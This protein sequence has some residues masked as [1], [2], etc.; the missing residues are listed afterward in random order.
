[1]PLKTSCRRVTIVYAVC[2]A[3]ATKTLKLPFLRLNRAKAEEFVRLQTLNTAV[4]ND[5]L[6]MPKAQRRALTSMSFAH[7]AIGAAWINQ[8]IRNANAHTKV[9]Q[10]RCLPLETNN[11][12]WTLH[13]VGETFSVA[14]GLLRGIKK[15]VP[16]AV[17]QAAHRQ[18]LNA[19]LDGSAKAG[20]LKLWRSQKGI[21]H[22]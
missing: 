19:V 11:Q 1:M 2:M 17:H 15:R 16:L 12:N 9:K 5:I 22:T 13:K 4:A 8:T 10:F 6:A 20:S 21:W 7:I 14:F 18:W 3:T